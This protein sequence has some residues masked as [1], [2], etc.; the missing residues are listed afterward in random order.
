MCLI[1]AEHAALE[2][3]LRL[4]FDLA[5]RLVHE[6]DVALDNVDARGV[7]VAQ[8]KL[9]L[10]ERL[11]RLDDVARTGGHMGAQLVRVVQDALDVAQRVAGG[12][13]ARQLR[14]AHVELV[15][16][17]ADL[18]LEPLARAVQRRDARLHYLEHLLERLDV[19]FV[20]LSNVMNLLVSIE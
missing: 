2:Y 12:L 20:S 10:V 5:P 6:G 7:E 11:R 3:A 13:Q 4:L 17:R 18:D 15:E 8:Q 14:D 9:E 16:G 19:Y 1:L